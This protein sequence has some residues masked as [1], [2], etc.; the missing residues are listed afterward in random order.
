MVGDNAGIRT[1]IGIADY[2]FFC[3][4]LDMSLSERVIPYVSKIGAFIS[5]AIGNSPEDVQARKQLGLDPFSKED[6]ELGL[7]REKPE[8]P[9][10]QRR[11]TYD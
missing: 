9:R 4:Y 1:L 11:R 7:P 2:P 5:A 8:P 10:Y 6:V 3:K